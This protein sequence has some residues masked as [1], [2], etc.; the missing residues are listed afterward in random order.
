MNAARNDLGAAAGGFTRRGF[1]GLAG[2]LF[3]AMAGAKPRTLRGIFPIMQSPFTDS[4]K[5][6]IEGLSR[7]VRFLDRAGAH[8]AVWPQLASEWDT[9]SQEERMAGAEAIVLAGRRTKL[10]IVLGVQGPDPEAAVRYAKQ[11]E[12]L[13][14]D[15][16][17]SL[18]PGDA[19]AKTLVD[20]YQQVGASTELPLFVQAVGDITPKVLLDLHGAV[21][22]VRY[23]KDEAGRPLNR[24]AALREGS[25]GKLTVFSGLHGRTLIEEMR[26]GF[27]GSMPAAAFADLYAQTWDLWQRARHMEAMEMH[28]RTLAVL[29]DMTLY[30]LEGLKYPL[31]LRGVFDSWAVRTPPQSPSQRLTEAG[32]RALRQALD[33][34]KPFLRA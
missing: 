27:A 26:R 1:L 13:G 17:I 22:T 11:A 18:P 28:G 4:N 29:A 5:L 14:A 20:Y 32:K 30:G 12:R 19:D 33:F 8:G 3:P 16:I 9:L 31:V 2:A 23:V 25:G 6:D 10:A 15:A 34:A 24:I 7:E 21:P